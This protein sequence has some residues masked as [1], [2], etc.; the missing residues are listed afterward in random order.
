MSRV[1]MLTKDAQIDRRILLEADSLEAAGWQVTILAMPHT[2]PD[3]DPRVVRLQRAAQRAQN[4]QNHLLCE[5]AV[6][7][8]WVWGVEGVEVEAQGVV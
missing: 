1:L 8:R 7:L 4:A 3:A 5:Q 6:V 2:V